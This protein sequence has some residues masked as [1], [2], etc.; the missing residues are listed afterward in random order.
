MLSA[1]RPVGFVVLVALS[2]FA[3]TSWA[4][5]KPAPGTKSESTNQ[6]G[7]CTVFHYAACQSKAEQQCG[8]SNQT[9]I[10][11]AVTS[12]MARCQ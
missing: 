5:Q 7:A 11:N 2:L 12:C 4:Q 3:S 9:C 10:T 1:V 8:T 6:A